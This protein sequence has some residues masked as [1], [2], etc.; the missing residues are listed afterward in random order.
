MHSVKTSQVL[1]VLFNLLFHMHRGVGY[2]LKSLHLKSRLK[3]CL[4]RLSWFGIIDYLLSTW[5][6]ES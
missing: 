1:E 2:L 3:D 6:S 4:Q 5:Q